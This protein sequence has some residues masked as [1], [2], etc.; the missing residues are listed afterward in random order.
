ME[1]TAKQLNMEPIIIPWMA[2]HSGWD[3]EHLTFGRMMAV[4]LPGEEVR[5]Q[6]PY[7]N[8][9]NWH[10]MPQLQ[11]STLYSG[12]E[13]IKE[14]SGVFFNELGYKREGGRYRCVEPNKEKIAV[15]CHGGFGLTW[16]AHLLEIP[17]PLVWS[18][19]WLPP[20]SVTTIL[21]DERSSE[22]AVPRCIGLGDVSHLYEA[23][24]TIQPRG[25][26]ANFD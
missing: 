9:E 25:I 3:I 24:L 2:E 14:H 12:F 19:F 20:S 8:H 22:W 4:D 6:S 23:G 26:K 17:L 10:Q 13:E 1:Y 15:F 11:N 21:F 18:G 16:L 5:S 7:P